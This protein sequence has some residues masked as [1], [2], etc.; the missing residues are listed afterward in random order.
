MNQ[1]I[2]ALFFISRCL[3]NDTRPESIAALRTEIHS[4]HL[5]WE[6]VVS[7][8]NGQL[9]TPALW[10]VLKNKDLAEELPTDLRN[11]L[12]ELHRLN[13]ERNTHLQTQLNI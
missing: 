11:Y 6:A 2:K 5:S 1:R 3:A 10:A 13:V 8:A 9:I 12:D 7:L 4:G